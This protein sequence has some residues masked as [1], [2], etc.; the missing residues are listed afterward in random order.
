MLCFSSKSSRN[1]LLIGALLLLTLVVLAGPPRKRWHSP[2]HG[3]TAAEL[4]AARQRKS[5]LHSKLYGLR[6][7]MKR[8]RA[9]IHSADVQADQITESI[10]TVQARLA[11]AKERIAQ[12]QSQ[13]KRLEDRHDALEDRMEETEERLKTRRELLAKRVRENYERGHTTYAQVL[14]Q[15]R[16]VHEMLSR[17]YYV[18][19][20][21]QSDADLI[22]SVRQDIA[23]IKADAAELEA[24]EKEQERLAAEYETQKIALVADMQRE[25]TL[26]AGVQA[27]KSEAED[28][29]DG[30]E[31][32][33]NS[34]TDRIRQLSEILRRRQQAQS[35]SGGNGGGSGR[36][37]RPGRHGGDSA[38]AVAWNG[39]FMRPVSGRIT[40]TFGYR[41]HPIQ[42]RRKLHTGIDFGV[43]SGTAIH[44]AGGGTVIMAGYSRGYGNCVIID[45]G[46]GVTTLYGHCSS[47]AVSEGQSV[48]KGQM[49]AYSGSTGMSTGPHLHWEVRHNGVPVHP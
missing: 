5:A 42:H 48:T 7:N 28:E 38:P 39:S 16:S 22:E 15:S 46:G 30:M 23:Q 14:L 49:I 26:L 10:E 8:V 9:K 41:Y 32:E 35:G 4:R 24:A 43:H 34:M 2:K 29:L 25:K 40:S 6:K 20:I 45:H 37:S 13:L 1:F 19:Q 47:L 31:D 27:A 33:A 12:T 18:K 11:S 3:P 44:A 21:V 36:P 17:E